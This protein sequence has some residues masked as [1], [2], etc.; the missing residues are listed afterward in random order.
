MIKIEPE[1]C[2]KLSVCGTHSLA[3]VMGPS[4]TGGK[5]TA[6]NTASSPRA[7]SIVLD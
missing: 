3:S 4:S 1:I 2:D 7:A 5:I 6:S